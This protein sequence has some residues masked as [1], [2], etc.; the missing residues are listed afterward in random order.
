MLPGA[1]KFFGGFQVAGLTALISADSYLSF[2]TN[3][4][5]TFMIVF[6]IPL[7]MVIADRIKPIPP[8]KLLAFEKYVIVAG[9][10]IALVVPFAFDFVTSLLIATPIIALY[11]ISVVIIMIRHGRRTSNKKQAPSAHEEPILDDAFVAELFTEEDSPS[12]QTVP[13]SRN[14]EFT[15]M[16]AKTPE[17]IR[18]ELA[19]QRQQALAAKVARYNNGRLVLQ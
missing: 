6:Q 4:L 13:R 18:Q 10:V 15:H 12:R 8:K 2:V 16:R 11:N 3:S 9:F 19:V 5:I 17:E 7:L 1:L 14:Y